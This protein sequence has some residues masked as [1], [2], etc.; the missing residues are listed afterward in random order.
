MARLFYLFVVIA[1]GAVVAHLSVIILLPVTAPATAA[2]Q[3]ESVLSISASSPLDLSAQQRSGAIELRLDP[4]FRTIGCQFDVSDAPFR[5]SGSGRVD[6]WSIS[7][8]DP[9]G[10]SIFSANDRIAPTTG[11]DLTVLSRSQLRVYRQSPDPRLQNSIIVTTEET[12]GFAIIRLFEPD[13]SWRSLIDAFVGSTACGSL[14]EFG[15][16]PR[17]EVV[18]PSG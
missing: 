10:V 6:F 16:A 7:I 3:L 15:L 13:E 1:V 5:V 2:R 18:D 14:E 11:I 4:A 17:E 8:L 9:L 12:T